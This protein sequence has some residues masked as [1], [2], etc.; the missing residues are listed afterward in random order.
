MNLRIESLYKKF[1]SKTVL[2]NITTI[3]PTGITGLLGPNGSGKTT[4][5]R[6]LSTIDNASAGKV[7]FNEK[8][9]SSSKEEIRNILGYL[10]QYF[11][12][13]PN[14][15][16]VEF[17]E[18]TATLKCIPLKQAK[19]RIYDL[20]ELLHL[21]DAMKKP[22]STFSG[23]MK[24]RVGIAQALL[25]DP[26]IL[27]IDEPTVGLDPDE[28]IQF[29]NLLS[30]ISDDKIVILSTHIV[31]DIEAIAP[32]IKIIK[33]GNLV[34]SS[35]PEELIK[36]TQGKVW[37]CLVSTYQLKDIQNKF[38]ISNSIQ[39]E[40][41]MQ[42]KI[43]SNRQPLPNAKNTFPTLEDAYLYSTSFKEE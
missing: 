17:L 42:V 43:I 12:V 16:A 5:M 41:G 15:T 23:G 19:K 20:L 1:G 38:L 22:L 26:K 13:Y 37:D 6:I 30:S 28:R 8:D 2:N 11:G 18:Y 7:Y 36:D 27:I 4:F 40:N 14:L 35:S 32:N 3:F 34:K 29:R 31:S 9:I 33:K 25:N 10:P 39:R 21:S 24:Q